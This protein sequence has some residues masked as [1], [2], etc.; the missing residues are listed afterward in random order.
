MILYAESSAVLAWLFAEPRGVAAV[1][2]LR[3]ADHV[4]VSDLLHVECDRSFIRAAALGALSGARESAVRRRFTHASGHWQ[5]LR[6]SPQVLDR[7]RQPF[8]REPIRTLDALHLASA[9]EARTALADVA[10]LSLDDRIRDNAAELG[11]QVL[12]EVLGE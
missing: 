9:L 6:I 5:A 4:V 12:P 2:A 10:I 7:S 8:P 1:D 3:A 11:F